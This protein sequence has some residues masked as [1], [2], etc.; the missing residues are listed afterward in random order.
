MAKCPHCN[1]PMMSARFEAMDTKEAFTTNNAYRAVAHCCPSCD[2]VLSVQI[3]PLALKS[4]LLR[5]VKKLLG[6]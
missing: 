6:R 5:G 4:D 3:D 1:N 2:A